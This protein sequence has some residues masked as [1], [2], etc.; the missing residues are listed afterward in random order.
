MDQLAQRIYLSVHEQGIEWQLS[1]KCDV[2]EM[3]FCFLAMNWKSWI[4][5]FMNFLEKSF[6]SSFNEEK[7]CW[8]YVLMSHRQ[9]DEKL[10]RSKENNELNDKINI[11]FDLIEILTN[12]SSVGFLIIWF[13]WTTVFKPKFVRIFEFY[14][15]LMKRCLVE[16]RLDFNRDKKLIEYREHILGFEQQFG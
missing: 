16:F 8:E 9:A 13:R 14:E 11:V 12:I 2:D 4:G 3:R 6:A 7:W 15:E 10:F 5:L 1:W